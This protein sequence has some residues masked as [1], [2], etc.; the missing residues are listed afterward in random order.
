MEKSCR[1]LRSAGHQGK[2]SL[3]S[4][5]IRGPG[6]GQPGR[7]GTGGGGEEGAEGAC[8][9]GRGSQGPERGGREG[10][11]P[12][13]H[14]GGHRAWEEAELSRAPHSPRA[15]PGIWGGADASL[16]GSAA[17]GSSAAPGETFPPAASLAR[18]RQVAGPPRPLSPG[19]RPSPPAPAAPSGRAF[20]SP[21]RGRRRQRPG[22]LLHRCGGLRKT[23]P[24]AVTAPGLGERRRH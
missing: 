9:G 1:G 18:G 11:S 19:Q 6:A 5:S 13:A 21:G 16:P 3:T 22:V 10:T 20:P 12:A 8:E 15:P 7:P 17:P 23:S 24:A 4:F 2:G 14:G